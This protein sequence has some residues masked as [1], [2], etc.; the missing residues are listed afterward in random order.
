VLPAVPIP[1]L[2]RRSLAFLSSLALLAAALVAGVAPAR[3]AAGD[4]FFSEYI[5]GTSFNKAIEI[6]NGTG[7]DVSLAGYRIE[8]YSNGAVTT[9]TA[10]SEDLTGTIT[11]GDVF[12]IAHASAA[13]AILAQ[14]DFVD[15][16]V[17]NWNG[18]DA[19][20]LRHNG[21]VIDSIGQVGFRPASPAEW[22]TG[23]TSTL[24][25]TLRRKASVTGGDTN[26]TNTFDPADEWLGFATDTFDGL[27]SPG[28]DAP[29]VVAATLPTNG[30]SGFGLHNN[31]YV[32]FSEPV[33]APPSVFSV[34]CAGA[35]IAVDVSAGPTTFEIDPHN[36]LP[37]ASSCSL[38]VRA[39]QVTDV[40]V[41]DPPD[42][43]QADRTV[44]F[45]TDAADA[46][47]GPSD[48]VGSV[49]GDQDASPRQGDTVT[50][51]GIVTADTQGGEGLN[52]VFIQDQGDGDPATSDGVFTF[53]PTANAQSLADVAVGDDIRLTGRA[54]EFSGMTEIDFVADLT[55]C[56]T[57]SVPEAVQ[58]EL[59]EAVDGDLE[60]V[61]GMYAS[62]SGPG[63]EPLTVEQNFFQGRYG[64]LTLGAGGRLFQPTNQFEPGSTEAQDLADLNKRSMIVLDDGS[65]AQNRDPVPFLGPNLTRR[66]G[67]TVS[68]LV[69]VIDYGQIN[70]NSAIRDF[71]LHALEAPTF[72][73]ANPRPAEPEQV[74]GTVKVAAVN[75]LNY[76]NTFGANACTFGVGGGSTECRGAS[77]L[78]EFDR[79][80]A[81]IVNEILAL[82]ADVVG[83]MEIEN[84]GYGPESAIQALVDALNA[85]AGAGTYDAVDVDTETGQLNAAGTDAIKVGLLYRPSRVA[86]V[87]QTAVLNTGA[88]GQYTLQ[89]GSVIGRHRPAVTQAFQDTESGERFVMSVNHF[90]SKG[91]GCADNVSPV[92]PDPDTGDG[93]GNCNLT[94]VAA[95]EQLT[96]WLA[97]DPTESGDSDALIMGDLNSYAKEDPV[98][99]IESAGY[100]NL[101]R[102]FVGPDAYSYVFDGMSGY[103]DHA[104]A[105]ASVVPQVTDVM[106][107]H[108]NADEPSVLDYNT[109]FKPGTQ[110]DDLY[111]SLPFRASDH[112]PVL[113]GLELGRCSFT[114]DAV[115]KVMTLDGDCST[116]ST[117]TVPGGWTLD[118]DG[119]TIS[120]YD[121]AG[122]HFVGSVVANGGA[123]ANV[124]NVTITAYELSDSC[125]A[126]DDRLRG[127][128]LDFA[129][130]SVTGTTVT[131]IRQAG[132]GCQEGNA[133]EVRNGPFD[134]TGPDKTVTIADNVVDDYQKTGILVN[135]SVNALV[136]GNDVSGLGP[137]PYIAQNGVQIGFGATA[138]VDG[139]RIADNWYTGTADAVSCGLLLFDADGVKQKRNTFVANQQDVCNF[140]RGGG[141]VTPAS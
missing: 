56:G 9:T 36:D 18:D 92:G 120:A 61:E 130:G 125:D 116:S 5:E 4:L 34:V 131:G 40:D 42:Q 117:I 22:G 33:N 23:L 20:V 53:L 95:A 81:K 27:G 114:E 16:G 43:M 58:V 96:A 51:Q 136:T 118:G 31:L 135:G 123:L 8:L 55:M 124:R 19:I 24:D 17:A 107:W 15:S 66:A 3:A 13:P 119:H 72:V 38:T 75:V 109:E 115:A 26:P 29:P 87:G 113:V 54:T 69:G 93:Q 88:F 48:T 102:Q 101:V 112:D 45:T 105:S 128:L 110:V 37:F 138:S 6:F 86:R 97:T 11:A 129:S 100:T 76:F 25:N 50:L 46:C 126:G 94:R 21:A 89:D 104:L 103:L 79:Q 122:E 90:K 59:P 91:S 7:A 1:A 98:R 137:V 12:V 77:N 32:A 68:N 78:A 83:L 57:T 84:D 70:S 73:N 47:G 106:E 99:T 28:E 74:G 141:S 85:E 133:I 121:P 10:G 67:D 49:Q 132:S 2:R 64:Q 111:S 80:E 39:A 44:T 82:D 62:V 60:R 63:G 134:T 30:L 140:G 52:G 127:I 139:N 14:A 108:T 71:R 35:P 65:N 41:S